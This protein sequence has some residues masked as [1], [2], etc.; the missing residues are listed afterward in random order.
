VPRE[1]VPAA[2]WV[3][4]ALPFAHAARF[5]SGALYDLSP[6][7]AVLREG[8]WLLALCFVFGTLARVSI[9]RLQG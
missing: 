6:W 3:S 9:R 4:D 7:G 2:G 8:A 5:F 1:I